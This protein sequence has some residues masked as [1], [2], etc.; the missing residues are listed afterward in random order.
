MADDDDSAAVAMTD[1]AFRPRLIDDVRNAILCAQVAD[2]RRSPLF[3]GLMMRWGWRRCVGPF[4]CKP[5][6][7][8]FS[9]NRFFSHLDRG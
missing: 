5:S 3:F 1:A 6:S 8:Q 2:P 7:L 4:L 9:L